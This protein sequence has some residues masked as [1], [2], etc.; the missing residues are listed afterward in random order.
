MNAYADLTTLK[1][2]SYLNLS[3]TTH[4]TYLTR[5]LDTASRQVDEFCRRNFYCS[6]GTRVYDG[7]ESIVFFPDDILSITTF[8][9]DED[10]D[11][12]YET[13]LT[14]DTDYVLCPYNKYPKTWA[15]LSSSG[16]SKISGFN[17]GVKKGLQV[18]GVFGYGDESS[19]GASPYLASGAIVNTG[20]I[21]AAAM[22]HALAT[23]K[24]ALFSV[25]MTIRIDS[26]QLYVSGVS[27]DTLTFEHGVNGTTSAAHS[28]AAVI[29]IYQYPYAVY[30][31]TLILA[32]RAWKRKDSA[33]QDVVGLG[34]MGTVIASK[35]FDA[36][37]ARLLMPY[38]RVN[39]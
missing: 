30:Q 17:D 2:A 1:S 16:S 4:D 9:M 38:V 32:M 15:E 35:G 23:G 6:E 33:Y 25:G 5:L 21:T 31:S 11:G 28:A 20:G 19:R 36:D 3:V 7:A 29:Y 24:G 8:K 22:T 18:I 12:T 14:A 10:C 26:E 34:E 39:Q 27:T 13:S 37:A